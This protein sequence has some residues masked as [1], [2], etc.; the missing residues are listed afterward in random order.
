MSLYKIKF[1]LIFLCATVLYSQ[2]KDTLRLNLIEK[3]LPFGLTYKIPDNLPRIGLAL[4]GGGARAISQIGILKAIEE[5]KLPID[6]IV[7]TS[8]G[9]VVGGLYSSGYGINELDSIVNSTRWETFFSLDQSE[10]N[11]LFVDQKITED[12]AVISLRID[13]FMPML[14]R[15]ISS[16]Q[17]SASFLNLI[18]LTAPVQAINNYDELLYRYRA[19]ATDLITGEKRVLNKGRL[20]IAMQ[21]SSSVTLL[22]PPVKLDS[23]LLV[24]GGLVANIPVKETKRMGAEIIIAANAVSPLY[25]ESELNYPWILA[26]Q[27]ISIPMKI[28]NEQQLEDADFIIQPELNDRKNSDFSEIPSIIETGYVAA[29]HLLDDIENMFE[30]MFKEKL[31][32][33]EKYYRNPFIR[34]A[35]DEFRN[36]LR[37]KLARTD[38]VS[39][40]DLVYLL[41]LIQRTGLYQDLFI[42]IETEN[43]TS[44]ISVVTKTNPPINSFELIGDTQISVEEIAQK[45]QPHLYKPYNPH[46]IFIAVLEILKIYRDNDFALARIEEISFDK[47]N[48][49][50]KIILDEGLISNIYVVGD[51]K[52]K[53]DIIVREFPMSAGSYFKYEDAERGLINLRSTNL[54]EQV[55]LT[56]D[57]NGD[58]NSLIINLIEKPSSILRLGMRLD[59]EYFTQLSVD[60]RDENFNGTGTEL[61]AILSGGIRNRSYVFE[62][63]ANRVFDTY[64]TYKVRAFY[65]FNDVHVYQND[66]TVAF[67]RYSRNRTGEYRQI[68]F[69]GN[70]GVGAQVERFGNV[71]VEARF[72]RDEIKSKSNYTEPVY[73]MDISSLRFSISIDSQNDYP[74]PTSGFLV[75]SY[76]ETAQTLLGG[77][78]GYTKIYFDYKSIFG[79]NTMHAITL[80]T[81]IGFGDETLPLSQQFSL[82]GQN[83]FFGMHDYEYRGRQIFLAS[84]EYRYKL[85]FQL[86]SDT[87]LKFRYDLG[88]SWAKKEQI[89]FKNLI[90]GVGATISFKTPLGPADFSAG[91]AFYFKDTLPKNTIVW[92]PTLLYFTIGYYF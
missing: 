61:G 75:N 12:R 9:S 68:F 23:F 89:K 28:L 50:L 25:Q 46:N 7:G 81:V 36:M 37:T 38:S 29:Q 79:L 44:F 43:N 76:Y 13:G 32:Y 77:D 45:I 51:L 11:E 42:E 78:I 57:K 71:F 91:K 82:G 80:R 70:F 84:A 56:V 16:G 1:L 6:I 22:L 88:S 85:P 62:H 63:K 21:A 33:G 87:Y 14:P 86:F 31:N 40:K 26:D 10:R 74:Y 53:K 39:N 19:I 90:H 54:F 30:T 59:N 15:S 58:E 92:G 67:N 47:I 65:D 60:I 49:S 3:K 8:M 48:N 83:S 41:Y 64:L 72:Q 27:L 34:E 24:D 35:P 73:K 4:S 20:G 18:S 66:T 17:R 69:G 52:T 55:E 5:R 2:H